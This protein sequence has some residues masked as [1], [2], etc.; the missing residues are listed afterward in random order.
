[1]GPR[2]VIQRSPIKIF[3][4][5]RKR[6]EGNRK[7][8]VGNSGKSGVG[9]HSSSVRRSINIFHWASLSC[10]RTGTR[11]KATALSVTTCP[12]DHEWLTTASPGV[13][14]DRLRVH[15]ARRCHGSNGKD[16]IDEAK[17]YKIKEFDK[18]FIISD[19]RKPCN[20]TIHRLIKNEAVIYIDH[21][22]T[23]QILLLIIMATKL[24]RNVNI[25]FTSYEFQVKQLKLDTHSIRYSTNKAQEKEVIIH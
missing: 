1:M 23:K 11:Y 2:L 25:K 10:A 24:K 3:G 9:P 12:S 13:A 8:I 21:L 4:L 20:R 14:L 16:L 15:V 19:M 7:E 22:D 18:P 6:S 17:K 5:F